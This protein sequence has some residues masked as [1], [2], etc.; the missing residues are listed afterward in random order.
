MTSFFFPALSQHQ[1]IECLVVVCMFV[2]GVTVV[3]FVERFR[4]KRIR[5]RER[6]ER[7]MVVRPLTVS[8]TVIDPLRPHVPV[9]T[10]TMSQYS[11][12]QVMLDLCDGY[13]LPP[14]S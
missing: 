1:T 10:G 14:K 6:M 13:I 11:A 2:V 5:E 8:I 3:D 12:S 7:R 4:D 9:I